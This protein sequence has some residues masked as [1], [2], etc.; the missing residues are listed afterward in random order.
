MQRNRTT[1]REIESG[2]HTTTIC[3]KWEPV[4]GPRL[5]PKEDD[6]MSLVGLN[7]NRAL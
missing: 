3:K 1:F 5:I 7:R 4:A 6:P 2:S